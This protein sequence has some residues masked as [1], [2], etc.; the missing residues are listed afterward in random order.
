MCE[1]R[2][3]DAEDAEEKTRDGMGRSRMV[4][5]GQ[6][7]GGMGTRV[8]LEN[9]RGR[10]EGHGGYTRESDG[11]APRRRRTRTNNGCSQPQLPRGIF[12]SRELRYGSGTFSAGGKVRV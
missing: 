5:R 8:W 3:E 4:A 1:M 6:P 2:T 11:C 9:G 10:R 7:G 12:Q